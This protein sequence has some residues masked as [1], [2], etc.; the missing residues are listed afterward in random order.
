MFRYGELVMFLMFALWIAVF[1]GIFRKWRW[2][3]GLAIL[4]LVVTV[5]LFKAHMTDPI[6]LNF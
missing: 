3:P 4:T 5:I 1:F 6:P 2:T